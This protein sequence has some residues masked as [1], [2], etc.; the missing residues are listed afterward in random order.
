MKLDASSNTLVEETVQIW[1]SERRYQKSMTLVTYKGLIFKS[2]ITQN[3]IKNLNIAGK[4]IN[5]ITISSR[6]IDLRAPDPNL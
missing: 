3:T 2:L 5:E 1:S 4:L 6:E